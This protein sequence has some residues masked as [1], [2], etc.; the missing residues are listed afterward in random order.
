MEQSINAFATVQHFA[1]QQRRI[2]GY[3]A[4]QEMDRLLEIIRQNPL[5]LEPFGYKV[6]S[7]GDEDGILE[8]IF[9]RLHITQGT[10]CEIGVE[11]GLECNSLWLLHKG[12]QG[13]WIEGNERQ[14]QPILDTFGSLLEQ[15]QL[16]V[17]FGF[18]TAENI[19]DLLHQIGITELDFLSID[20]D[21]NDIFLLENLSLQPKVI[22]IE[23]NGKFP[24]TLAMLPVYNPK[25]CWK[26]DDYMGSS[27]RALYLA[28]IEKGYQ[29]VGT[30]LV[31]SNAFFVRND[32]IQDGVWPEPSPSVLYNPS[33]YWLLWDHFSSIGHKASFGDYFYEERELLKTK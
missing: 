11:N 9:R 21:G 20:I 32:L 3:L 8:E 23:Y 22:C 27:L 25:N 10:F 1:A 30:T 24:P 6:Y 29:L 31:G 17:L 14:R 18:V 7:Q 2:A 13:T 26:G 4:R 33:R 5:R 16:K 19:N 12:W 28:G 15:Q